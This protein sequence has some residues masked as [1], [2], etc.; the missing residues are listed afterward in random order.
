MCILSSVH[1]SN[2]SGLTHVGPSWKLRTNLAGPQLDCLGATPLGPKWVCW[3]GMICLITD[4][5]I[6]LLCFYLSDSQYQLQLNSE[7]FFWVKLDQERVQRETPSW[8]CST[9]RQEIHK[10]HLLKLVRKEMWKLMKGGSQSL[11]LRACLIRH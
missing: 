7:L 6:Y 4:Y 5:F 3:L 9:L 2:S 8:I 11:I 10:S 1:F